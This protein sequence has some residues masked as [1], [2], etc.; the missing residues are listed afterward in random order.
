[1]VT[2]LVDEGKVVDVGFLDFRKAF[3]TVPH[4]IL[5]DKLP[6]C[7]TSGL[8]VRWVKNW[9]N[10]RVQRLVVHVSLVTG[11]Q[12]CYS[13]LGPVLFNIFSND[14][15]TGVECTISKFADDTKLGGAVESLG[16]R[17][18]SRGIWIK[19]STGK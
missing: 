11:H 18:F 17:R 19:W 4:S 13:I 12:W 14:L 16:G 3:D 8:M 5:L 6:S 10:G 1:V 15:D 7:G 9:Q 2:Y